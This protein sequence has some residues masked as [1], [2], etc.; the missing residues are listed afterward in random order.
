MV[1]ETYHCILFISGMSVKSLQAIENIKSICD[2]HLKGHIDLKIIDISKERD[3]AAEYQI[4]ALPTLIKL[5]P[6]PARTILG[7]LSDKT[8]V[9]KILDIL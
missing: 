5:G 7:N 2:E 1:A 3:K 9:L 6:K 8:K 4:L